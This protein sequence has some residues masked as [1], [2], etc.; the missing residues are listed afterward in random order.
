MHFYMFYS[1]M[2]S[3]FFLFSIGLFLLYFF[4]DIVRYAYKRSNENPLNIKQKYRL[5]SNDRFGFNT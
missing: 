3:A 2:L 1:F 5:N 4:L